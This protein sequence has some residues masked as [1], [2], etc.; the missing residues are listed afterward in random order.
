MARNRR[1]EKDASQSRPVPVFYDQFCTE[2]FTSRMFLA[3]SAVLHSL[4]LL[5][6]AIIWGGFLKLKEDVLRSGPLLTRCE[7]INGHPIPPGF[8]GIG[9]AQAGFLGIPHQT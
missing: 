9:L 3:V 5:L 1:V 7:Q 4:S 6:R 8:T 2:L